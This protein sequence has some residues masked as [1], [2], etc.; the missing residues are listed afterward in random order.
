[1]ESIENLYTNV[2]SKI[3]KL[4]K[5]IGYSNVIAAVITLAIA[6]VLLFD[7]EEVALI[8]MISA[9]V[10]GAMGI[11]TSWFIYAFGQMV[12]DVHNIKLKSNNQSIDSEIVLP[13]L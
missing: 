13:K 11:F 9:V 3:M 5:A 6:V 7:D 4:G 12:N 2:G 1:M 10:A 8:L